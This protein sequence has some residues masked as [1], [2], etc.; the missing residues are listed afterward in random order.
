MSALM[1]C[2][3]CQGKAIATDIARARRCR[4]SERL[5]GR[6]GHLPFLDLF[7]RRHGTCRTTRFRRWAAGM[8]ER[9]PIGHVQN[10]HKRLAV[11]AVR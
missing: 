8:A 7:Q 4:S 9:I 5:H 11:T 6:R 2:A 10:H 1:H 3:G